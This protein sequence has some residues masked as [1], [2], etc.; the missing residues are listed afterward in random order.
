VQIFDFNPFIQNKEETQMKALKIIQ[1]A[2][3]VLAAVV[4]L[5]AVL[6]GFGVLPNHL[7]IV[8][9]GALQRIADTGLFFSIAVGMYLIVNKKKT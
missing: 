8:K 1:W 6:T 3:L 9:T 2:S 4:F 7:F 5:L